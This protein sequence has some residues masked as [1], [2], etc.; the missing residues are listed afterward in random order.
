MTRAPGSFV[1]S[2]RSL[3]AVSRSVSPIADLRGTTPSS[4]RRTASVASSHLTPRILSYAG[5]L[6]G[7]GAPRGLS[8]V[9][10]EGPR[11]RL[12]QHLRHYHRTRL[13]LAPQHLT[14]W[15][16]EVSSYCLYLKVYTATAFS[17]SLGVCQYF[18]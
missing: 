14:T 13:W 11:P 15:V 16:V 18:S 12:P 4:L 2:T 1:R 9:P 17:L 6:G 5:I 3:T 10:S 7:D 8:G